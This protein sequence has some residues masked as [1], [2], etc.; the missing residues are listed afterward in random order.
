MICEQIGV[1]ITALLPQDKAV[2]TYRVPSSDCGESI[3]AAARVVAR[4][5][6]VEDRRRSPAV[7]ERVQPPERGPA[8]VEQLVVD[9]CDEARKRR[10]RRARAADEEQSPGDV[11]DE[12]RPLHGDVG[13][14]AARCVV[15]ARVG[16]A[17][18]CQEGRYRAVLE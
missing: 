5:D 8:G 15:P 12:V 6:V 3:R 13:E 11:D 14:A 18:L 17:E 10:A 1:R 9:K 16:R 2:Y 4:G 7:Q